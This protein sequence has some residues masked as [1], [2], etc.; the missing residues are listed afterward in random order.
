MQYDEVR[1]T[2]NLWFK[3]LLPSGMKVAD[4]DPSKSKDASDTNLARWTSETF[5]CMP[6]TSLFCILIGQRA[7]RTW[8][9]AAYPTKRC[10]QMLYTTRCALNMY[11][12]SSMLALKRG[13][14]FELHSDAKVSS[15]SSSISAPA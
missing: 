7:A 12:L 10:K 6:F 11:S 3:Q 4:I 1:Y 13:R 14:S 5:D 15:L 8:T 2:G 9:S